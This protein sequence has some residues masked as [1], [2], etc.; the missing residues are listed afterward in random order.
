MNIEAFQKKLE[1]KLGIKDINIRCHN[2]R[3]DYKERILSYSDLSYVKDHDG[4]FINISDKD[5]MPISSFCLMQMPGCC[6]ICISYNSLIFP[7]YQ[8]KGIGTLLNQFRIDIA[9]YLGYTTL[10]CTD[11]EENIPQKKILAKNGWKDVHSF[12][13]KRTNNL[14]N[15]TIKDI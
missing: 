2:I 1:Q 3:T 4:L 12:V 10:L 5:N 8:G 13:N 14:V 9:D 7:K 15:I 6:G 11:R